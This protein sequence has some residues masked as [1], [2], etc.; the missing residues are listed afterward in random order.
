MMILRKLILTALTVF[1]L[2][3]CTGGSPNP[4]NTQAKV[5]SS[6]LAN[7]LFYAIHAK[8]ENSDKIQ[9]RLMINAGSL[10]E[11]DTQKG[12]AHL[13]EHMAFNGTKHFPKNKIIELFE[14]SGLTF[15]Q[16][17]NAYTHFDVTVYTLTVPKS[18]AQLLADTILYLR[19]VLTDIEFD[20][21]EL[22]KEQGVV[23]NEYRLRV[24]Q[25]K[26]YYYAIFDDYIADSPYADRL[27]VVTI[28]SVGNSTELGVKAFYKTWYRPDNAKLLITGD[29]N[30]VEAAR[31]INEAFASVPSSHNKSRQVIPTVPKIN[32]E[33]KSYSSKVINYS[34]SDLFIEMPAFSIKSSDDISRSMQ[35]RLLD[36]LINYRLN[37]QNNQRP[38]PFTEIG[39]HSFEYF[40]NHPVK[41]LYVVHNNDQYQQAVNFAAQ[42]LARIEQHGF[43]QA[44][45]DLQLEEIRM[46]LSGLENDYINKT[47]E[48]LASDTINSWTSGNIEHTLEIERLA[49]QKTLAEADLHKLKQLSKTLLQQPKQWNF[50]YPYQSQSPDLAA[51]QKA[52]AD[53][54]K[55]PTE[56]ADIKIAKLTLPVISKGKN[57][58]RI[59]TEKYHPEKQLTEWQLSN[60]V[61][62]VLQP[63]HS[64]KNSI[65]MGLSAPGGTNSL[66]T[67]QL[68]AAL[69]LFNS[70]INSGIAGLSAQ[71]LEQKFNNAKVS[72]IPYMEQNIHG[73]TMTSENNPKSLELL[74]SVLYS[75]FTEARIKETVFAAE[76]ERVI[77]AQQNY[78]Q[79]AITNTH[80]RMRNKLFPGNAY[81]RIFSVDELKAV[82]QQ[83]VEKIYQTL[84]SHANGYTL[85]IVGDF[86]VDDLKAGIL[87]YIAALPSGEMHKFNH[88][89]Q[90][91]IKHASSLNENTNP[92]DN[93][94]V[95]LFSITDTPNKN[96]K[97]IYQADLLQRIISRK[98]TK[99]IREELSLTYSPYVM[100]ADQKPGMAFTEVM[101][102]VVAKV[103]D[104]QQTQTEIR[105]IITDFIN[106]GISEEQLADHKKGLLNGMSSVLKTADDRQWF[107]QRDHLYGFELSS[108][109]KAQ[110]IIEA[111]TLT[112][113]NAFLRTYL[114]PQHTLQ[115]INIPD[116]S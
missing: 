72:L 6:T 47:S 68:P 24:P 8:Q 21:A 90:S 35:S 50:A 17:I 14:K 104:A 4:E 58:S 28:E 108:T 67:D 31:L 29:V 113:M 5:T 93:A 112:D 55:K 80:K 74:F 84:F 23:Q 105:Q 13:L 76:K 114:A 106:N 97:E 79:Q 10:S 81:L 91:I 98:L 101:I 64:V 16:D 116:K 73:F 54:I 20:Q 43:S 57:A 15:G 86:E 100:V 88:N 66:S 69:Y 65:F 34:Q 9:L 92:Q 99:I 107:L 33:S 30:T 42:E 59:E 32:T 83:E 62:V 110:S 38:Q 60:G 46:S 78:L 85:T 70:Y 77:E 2:S 18:D 63:D 26:P 1:L 11:T 25:E 39:F 111:I 41:Q 12:Y 115:F 56:K 87:Q 44:E 7:G 27:P 94:E 48:Q 75:A 37:V 109:E 96:I 102:S 51:L 22:D 53:T 61:S 103:E 49:Y 45:L 3:A 95:L 36:N 19:D 40:S 82:Q 52:A 89:R 71:Q